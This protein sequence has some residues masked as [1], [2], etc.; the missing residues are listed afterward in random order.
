MAATGG[1]RC[2]SDIKS[3]YKHWAGR[4]SNNG[5]QVLAQKAEAQPT[6]GRYASALQ[7]RQEHC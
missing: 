5:S 7:A 4:Q 2:I 3:A 1:R 6:C